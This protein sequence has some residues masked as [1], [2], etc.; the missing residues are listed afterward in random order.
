M[1]RHVPKKRAASCLLLVAGIMLPAPGW[2]TPLTG[3]IIHQQL[4]DRR[5][6]Y[7]VMG[8]W[9][10][11]Y[12]MG[13]AHGNLLADDIVTLVAEAKKVFGEKLYPSARA[14]AA[15]MVWEPEALER[16][17]EGMLAG[18]RTAR[19]AAAID[20]IDL[21]V[22]NTIG[23]WFYPPACNSHSS[24]GSLVEGPARALHS[25]RLDT[26]LLL[27][28]PAIKHHL[29]VARQAADGTTMRWVNVAWP[30][31]V[32][33]LTG[34]NEDGVLV[35][36]H[37]LVGEMKAKLEAGHLPRFV[38]ARHALTVAGPVPVAQ[39]LDFVFE[40]LRRYTIMSGGF[41]NFYAPEGQ[42]GVIT[43][44]AGRRCSSVRR[45]RPEF[46]GGEVLITTNFETDGLAAPQWGE[47]ID[48][49][50]RAGGPR[51]LA[52]HFNL[53]KTGKPFSPVVHLLSVAYRARGDM[54]LRFEGV[55]DNNGTPG[56]LLELEFADLFDRTGPASLVLPAQG[57]LEPLVVQPEGGCA[58]SLAR[59]RISLPLLGCLL[60]I[61][62]LL[63]R[64]RLDRRSSRTEHERIPR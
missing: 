58:V 34:V 14:L 32:T 33:S 21:K 25:R 20:A 44:L 46:H 18:I 43:C 45:P 52:E 59:S 10:T 17:L 64:R 26:P 19:P 57:S 15:G 37:D 63:R 8:L 55:I 49:S 50:Y 61:H 9:G 41:I 23:D 6:G 13:L 54:S 48:E 62:V 56:P 35:S 24:W 39:Q 60:A 12:E 16:E 3:K 47:Y 29:L 27:V 42:G 40:S 2:A 30:G 31:Y 22:V 36:L 7:T 38:A 51:T 11:H 1:R 28:T 5:V 53:L 4:D